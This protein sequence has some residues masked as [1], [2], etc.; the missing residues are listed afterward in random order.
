MDLTIH[1][2][3]SIEAKPI[4]ENTTGYGPFFCRDIIITAIDGQLFRLVLFNHDR[5][6]LSVRE[7]A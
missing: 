4:K 2:V 7:V 5:D 3:T 1:G 6:A